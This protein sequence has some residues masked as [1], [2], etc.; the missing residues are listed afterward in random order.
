MA[1]LDR[2]G[3]ARAGDTDGGAVSTRARPPTW[4]PSR[5]SS[6]HEIGPWTDMYAL[7]CRHGVWCAADHLV[8]ETLDQTLDAHFNDRVPEL[9]QHY[10]S[11]PGFE[12]WVNQPLKVAPP[13]L[14]ACGRCGVLP[15]QAR[16]T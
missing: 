11:A 15:G 1:G 5:F 8:H 3:L 14:R 7:G 6:L 9:V 13:A 12:A 4:H 10:A 16:S 2:L